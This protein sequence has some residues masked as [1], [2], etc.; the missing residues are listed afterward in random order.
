MVEDY[1]REHYSIDDGIPV[2]P[3]K[4]LQHMMEAREMEPKDLMSILN[5]SEE[6]ALLTIDGEQQIDRLQALALGDYFKVNSNNFY[7]NS[8]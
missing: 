6:I 1:E 8:Y 4:F 7:N 3:H 5:I 2:A